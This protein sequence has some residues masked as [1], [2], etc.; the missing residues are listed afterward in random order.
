[1]ILPRARWCVFWPRAPASRGGWT[2]RQRRGERAVSFFEWHPLETRHRHGGDGLL[3]SRGRNLL[4]LCVLRNRDAQLF[5][6]FLAERS[7]PPL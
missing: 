4:P 6:V 1:M 5:D 3:A 7:A 2:A